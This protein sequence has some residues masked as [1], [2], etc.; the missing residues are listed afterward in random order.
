MRHPSLFKP[1]RRA[2]F[3]P[4]I[5][6]SLLA[7]GCARIGFAIA[8][9]GVDASAISSVPFDPVHGLSLDVHRPVGGVGKAPVVVFFH[10]GSWRN[11]TRQDYRFAGRSLASAGILAIVPDYRKAPHVVF[12]A[13]VEDGA[14]AV[15]WARAHAAEY[16]GDPSRIYLM[17][18]SSGAH[19]AAMLGAD[20]RYLD[21]VG[22][23][24]RELAGVIGLSGPYDFLPIVDPDVAQA[25][26][27]ESAWPASQPVNFVDGDEPRFLLLQGTADDLVRP[28]N[29]PSLARKLRDK[30]EPVELHMLDG[31]GHAG[32]LVGLV[33]DRSPVRRAVLGY[34]TAPPVIAAS[35]PLR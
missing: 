29:A 22:V 1:V 30:G 23:R 14:R 16:G 4:A 5:L 27:P 28:R 18:H 7:T 20:A 21:T 32:T 13:F 3:V 24:P 10:G 33:R 17:G 26:G 19:I 11:G 2:V 12:P 35:A 31:M 34:I 8:N 15:A 6:A 9:T 25:L